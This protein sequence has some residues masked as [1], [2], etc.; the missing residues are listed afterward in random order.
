MKYEIIKF[1]TL[2]VAD[3]TPHPDAQAFPS[4]DDDR[5]ALDAS[6]DGVGILEPLTVIPSGSAYLVIDGCGRLADALAKGTQTLPCLVVSCDNPREFANNKNAMGRK[7]STGSRI[8]CYL[9][10]NQKA[11]LEAASLLQSRD[12]REEAFKTPTHLKPWTSREIARRL[13]V[14][15]TDVVSAIQLLVCQTSNV[16]PDNADL[17]DDSAF[18]LDEIFTSVMCART[19]VRR[20]KAAYGGKS[21][22]ADGSGKAATDYSALGVRTLVSLRNVFSHWYDIPAGSRDFL[23]QDLR[24][25]LSA[26]PEEVRLAVDQLAKSSK[27]K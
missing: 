2:P 9:M 13:K 26:A 21:V 19:P 1:L 24:G 5:A 6:I 20:W 10:A 18:R 23:L 16:S 3:L 12:R 11:V 15:D 27:T 7:R 8:L 17:D 25:I 14:S 22:P 4:D